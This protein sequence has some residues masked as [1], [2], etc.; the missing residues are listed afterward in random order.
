M[1]LIEGVGDEVIHFFLLLAIVFVV[2]IAWWSTNLSERP[3]IRTVFI[4]ERR[5][6]R[7]T[8]ADIPTITSDVTDANNVLQ[9]VSEVA[10]ENKTSQSNTGDDSQNGVSMV[11]QLNDSEPAPVAVPQPEAR[12][13]EAE[14]GV[15]ENTCCETDES[16][17][18]NRKKGG[19]ASF[20]PGRENETNSVPAV[21]VVEENTSPSECE[22]ESSNDGN[23]RIRL[24]YLNDD[25]KLV[26]GKLQEQLGDFKRRHFS[27][28]LA[29][30]KLVRLIFKGQVLQEDTKTLQNCGFFD[31]C[32]VH[33]LVHSRTPPPVAKSEQASQR[34]ST[35]Q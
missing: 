14:C 4:V 18:R 29:G 25:Q 20:D 9:E 6:I 28:E 32:V 11:R 21:D 34:K 5:T 26:E 31:N 22:T 2:L 15:E 24:K 30:R 19:L 8:P 16:A 17:V 35:E 10:E 27:L 13:V 1:T 3:L 7:R 12:P 23:I 33:C